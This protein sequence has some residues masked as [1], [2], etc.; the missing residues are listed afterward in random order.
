[1]NKKKVDEMIPKAVEALENAGIVKDGKIKKIYRGYI[2]TFGA[3]IMN[4]S[5]LAA[6]A[7]FSDKG[8]ATEERPKLMDAVYRVL[9]QK[10]KSASVEKNALFNYVKETNGDERYKCRED[11]INASIALKLAM[12]VFELED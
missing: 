3:S 6:V 8:S 2:S 1:M 10:D 9:P 7:F 4:G 5:L 11:I 12:N